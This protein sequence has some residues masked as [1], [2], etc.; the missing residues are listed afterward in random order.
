[1]PE[2]PEVEAQRALIEARGLHGST[3]PCDRLAERHCAGRVVS[4]V[5]T[6]EQGGGPRD[7]SFDDIVIDEGV[8]AARLSAAL[9][10][11]RIAE[12]RRKGKQLY[13]ILT[14]PTSPAGAGLGNFRF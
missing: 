14:E 6:V 4:S 2:L 12:C 13:C 1:M 9:S 8:T 3:A 5:V 7:G 10:G 11:R